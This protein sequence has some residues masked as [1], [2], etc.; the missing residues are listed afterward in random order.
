M[1]NINSKYNDDIL[2][3]MEH[4]LKKLA[5]ISLTDYEE[6]LKNMDCNQLKNHQPDRARVPGAEN[7]EKAKI[8]KKIL[9]KK[10]CGLSADDK[11]AVNFA[12][13]YITKIADELDKNGFVDVANMLDEELQKFAALIC[14]NCK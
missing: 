8:Y 9:A 11:I 1:V 2:F 4:E 14:E 12:I 5:Y 3:D 13:Q 10:G 6:V 7:F